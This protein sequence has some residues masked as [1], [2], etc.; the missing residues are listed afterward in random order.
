MKNGAVNVDS[1]EDKEERQANRLFTYLVL[2]IV[3][4]VLSYAI[5]LIFITWPISD[6]SIGA[7]GTF[8]DSFGILTSL[9]S[10]IAFAGLIW[11]ILLQ[12]A[13]LKLQRKELIE[14]RRQAILTRLM[15][16][17]QNQV[18]SYRAELSSIKFEDITDPQNEIGI[19]Q[20]I[21]TM[22][23][24]MGQFARES[25]K[26]DS[27]N[28]EALTKYLLSIARSNRSYLCLIQ[29]L[30]RCCDSNRYILTNESISPE[31]AQDI[32][33]LM[34]AELPTGLMEFVSQLSLLLD[35]YVTKLAKSV[36]FFDPLRNLGNDSK[37]ILS[38]KSHRFTKENMESDRKE[39]WLFEE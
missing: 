22:T 7:A 11:T 25:K 33:A 15:T 20:M 39:K 30:R 14:A 9:F 17:T 24:Y 8:G 27:P 35:M 3:L 34:F 5:F 21:F 23:A 38:H 16:V 26:E 6:L 12:R 1:G 2:G 18:S 32:K 36:D 31:E 19:N 28:H 37:M 13:E 10:G 4:L 29:G